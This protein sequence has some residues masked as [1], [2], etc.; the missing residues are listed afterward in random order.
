MNRVERLIYKNCES[1]AKFKNEKIA[2]NKALKYG[3]EYFK[4]PIC[5]YY[6]LTKH[7]LGKEWE[8]DYLK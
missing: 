1:K 5:G 2:M 3:I 4:C 8:K 7:R 6:H